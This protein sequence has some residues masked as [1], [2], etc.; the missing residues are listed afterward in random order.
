MFGMPFVTR[1][2]G[3]TC[4]GIRRLSGL[5]TGVTRDKHSMSREEVGRV[6]S[7]T[8]TIPA[9]NCFTV[10][11]LAPSASVIRQDRRNK[12]VHGAIIVDQLLAADLSAPLRPA[13]NTSSTYLPCI[14]GERSYADSR[15]RVTQHALYAHVIKAWRDYFDDV[16]Y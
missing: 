16:K 8:K 3:I 5:S 7:T 6:V 13:R 4:W 11:A 12:G 15:R 1:F 9:E 2:T 10:E 14:T